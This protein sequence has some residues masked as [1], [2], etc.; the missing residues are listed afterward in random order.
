MSWL[1]RIRSYL[2]RIVVVPLTATVKRLQKA[3]RPSRS[4]I[5]SNGLSRRASPFGERKRT[6]TRDIL[7]ISWRHAQDH[8]S[9]YVKWRTNGRSCKRIVYLSICLEKGTLLCLA[10]NRLKQ[11]GSAH[12]WSPLNFI[13]MT[14]INNAISIVS[15]FLLLWRLPRSHVA[16]VDTVYRYPICFKG[17]ISGIKR[18]IQPITEKSRKISVKTNR[19]ITVRH[20]VNFWSTSPRDFKVFGQY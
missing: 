13:W 3:E 4:Y 17:P 9:H 10:S 14:V 6:L 19:L 2:E 20:Y 16:F 15:L 12:I 11:L 7:N 5:L 8:G 18:H 1:A